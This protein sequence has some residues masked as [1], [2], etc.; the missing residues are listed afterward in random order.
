VPAAWLAIGA[1]KP[2]DT[3]LASIASGE[4][5]PSV[6]DPYRYEGV[7]RAGDVKLGKEHVAMP[8]F[9]RE[10]SRPDDPVFCTTW[11]LGGGTEAFLSD[12]RNP[13]SFDKP[14]EVVSRSQ[15]RRLLE[16]LQ[17]DPP[18]LVV[19][20]H[21]DEAGGDVAAYIKHGWHDS[22][23]PDDPRILQRNW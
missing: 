12:R 23:F 2:L 9:V 21:F 4:E 7:P 3:R 18:V 14:D 22:G 6:G 11:L 20:H 8:R 15:Q 5:R 17:R 1:A 16:E 10:H 13:T 19:G